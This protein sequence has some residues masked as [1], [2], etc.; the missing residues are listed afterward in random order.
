LNGD[1]YKNYQNDQSYGQ[2]Y[3]SEPGTSPCYSVA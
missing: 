3:D 2:F 1:C